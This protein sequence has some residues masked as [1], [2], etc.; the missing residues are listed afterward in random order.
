MTIVKPLLLAILLLFARFFAFSQ[1]LRGVVKDE[2]GLPVTSATIGLLSLPDSSLLKEQA[3]DTAGKFQLSGIGSGKFLLRTTAI[4]YLKNEQEVNLATGASSLDLSIVL[5]AGSDML[6]AVVVRSARPVFQQVADRLVVNV[7][8]NSFFKTSSNGF[9]ILRRIPGL[10]ISSEGVLQ[11][12]GR[13]TPAIYIDGKPVQ[14]SAEEIQ[15]YL[16]TIT[17]DMIASV[18]VISNPS[19]RFDGDQKGIIDIK[20][21][22]NNQLGWKGL[23]TTSYQQNNY[24][25]F[26][27]SLLLTYKTSKLAWTFRGAYTGGTRI[28]RYTSDQRLANTNFQHTK[29]AIATGNNITNLQL[30]LDYSLAKNQSL[31]LV[32]RTTQNH[33]DINAFGTIDRRDSADK[34]QLWLIGTYNTSAPSLKTYGGNLNYSIQKGHTRIQ[35]LNSF[36]QL[37]SRQNENIISWYSDS[38]ELYQHWKSDLRLDNKLAASQLDLTTEIGKGKFSVGGKFAYTRIENFNEYDTLNKEQVFVIDAG[39][40]NSFNYT[41]YIS[42]GYLSY[43][44]AI[45]KFTITASFRAE[46]TRTIADALTSKETTKRNYFSWLPS[47]GVSYA[48]NENNSFQLT[49]SRRL[50]RPEFQALN[51]FRLYFSPL[52][53][54]VGNPYLQPATTTSVNASWS[55]KTLNIALNIG[56]ESD[57]LGRY[58]RYNPETNVLEYLGRNFMSSD[59]ANLQISYPHTIKPWWKINHTLTGYYSKERIP[60]LEYVFANPVYQFIFNGSQVF[61]LPGNWLFDVYYYYRSPFG[62][63]LYTFKPITY[64]NLGLQKTW[65]NGRLNSKLN[66]NDIFDGNMVTLTFRRKELIDNTLSHWNGNKKLVLTLSFN[67][68]QSTYKAK[69]SRGN[70]EENRASM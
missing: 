9:D 26:D 3:T 5:Q 39:R 49:F 30:G 36:L 8:G 32:L 20:L 25:L 55:R 37:N 31:E 67:F 21:R 53:Y 33:R 46:N 4:G 2:K 43:E 68:G 54:F 48:M 42:A 52:N 59:F 14:M 28:Y 69:Q 13:T 45:K 18:E 63:S 65:F 57:P 16:Q 50:T 41:E 40:T 70:E 24:T 23:I 34:N 7:A 29:N 66:F 60:Y 11:M 17:P 12:N 6:G 51:P 1:T 35:W 58:P 56:H 44:R 47:A 64:V 19:A 61:T 62:N 15:Q 38:K 10:D 27:N 22:R